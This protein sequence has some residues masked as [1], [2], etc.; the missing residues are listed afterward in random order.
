MVNGIDKFKEKFKKYSDCYTIIGGA[1]CDVLM[2]ETQFDFRVTKDIDMIILLED[3]YQEFAEAFWEYIKEGGY[4]CGWK[5]NDKLHFYRFTEPYPG[6]PIMIELF[7]RRPD[8][9]LEIK[10]AII[11]IH[12]DDDTS[13]LSAILLNDDFYDFMIQGRITIDGLS[14]LSAEYLIPFKMYAWLDLK[15]RK[16]KGEFVKN[17]DIKKHKYDVFRLLQIVSIDKVIPTSGLV[18]DTVFNFVR[19]IKDEE[20]PLKQ[21]NVNM[22]LDQGL[23]YLKKLYGIV[24]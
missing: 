8:Y 5:N 11:P 2:K 19:L 17:A 9:H 3:R 20:I 7:S 21:I 13:S 16:E 6:Y 18:R 1:A 14:V 24:L 4:K 22:T 15:N 10:N 23:E 12:I